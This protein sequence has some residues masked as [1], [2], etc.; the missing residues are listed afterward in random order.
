MYMIYEWDHQLSTEKGFG[1]AKSR[2]VQDMRANRLKSWKLG[3][4]YGIYGR[5]RKTLSVTSNFLHIMLYGVW[6]TM[7]FA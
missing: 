2:G 7:D 1:R 3:K 6:N 4:Q 5:L